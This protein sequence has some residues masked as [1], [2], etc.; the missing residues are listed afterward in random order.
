MKPQL[1]E[2]LKIINGQPQF[3]EF[4]QQRIDRSRQALFQLSESLD[5]RELLGNA[6]T[7][8]VYRCRVVYSDQLEFIEYLPEV[9]RH[10][11]R[12]RLVTDNTICYDYKFLQRERLTELWNGRGKGDDILIVKHG[13]ITDTS[14][15]NVAFFDGSQWLTPEFP[16]LLGTTRARLLEKKQLRIAQIGVDDLPKFSKL[17]L[18]N[19]M[20]GFYIVENFM[21]DYDE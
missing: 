17:A 8:G 2:T 20:L 15:A 18:M 14:V 12:F 6:P 1:L 19:A 16:L 5:L 10:F 9:A 7:Q 11:Q 13:L 4:H 3:L 21:I